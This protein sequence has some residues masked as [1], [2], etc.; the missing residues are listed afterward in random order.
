VSRPINFK[1]S[2]LKNKWFDP[3][4]AFLSTSIQVIPWAGIEKELAAPLSS[5]R[6]GM[7]LKKIVVLIFG[8]VVHLKEAGDRRNGNDGCSRS[9]SSFEAGTPLL[10]R[11]GCA[12]D[13]AIAA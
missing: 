1:I 3:R 12:A 6:L 5:F 7:V 9:L 2:S 11:I 10:D 4:L 8:K 13:L